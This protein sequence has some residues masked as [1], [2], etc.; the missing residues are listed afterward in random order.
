[1]LLNTS[2]SPSEVQKSRGPVSC[3]SRGAQPSGKSGHAQQSP[4][5]PP[6]DRD[7]HVIS[8]V[9]GEINTLRV[10]PHTNGLESPTISRNRSRTD[11]SEVGKDL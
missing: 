8:W 7:E 4:H 9:E 1:L 6:T 11:E 10:T 2:N 5:T 3:K